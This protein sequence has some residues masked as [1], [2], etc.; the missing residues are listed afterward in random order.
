MEGDSTRFNQTF[1]FRPQIDIVTGLRK[2]VEESR[3][4]K[5]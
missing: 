5:N 4:L 2:L 1:A 3:R